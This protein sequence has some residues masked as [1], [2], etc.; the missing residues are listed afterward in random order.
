MLN[1]VKT[2]SLCLALC[3]PL[4]AFGQFMAPPPTQEIRDSIV[5]DLKEMRLPLSPEWRFYSYFTADALELNVSTA[6]A[7]QESAQS[8]MHLAMD[9]FWNPQI[10]TNSYEAAGRGIY[11]G[12]DPLISQKYGDTLLVLSIKDDGE[13]YFYLPYELQWSEKTIRLFEEMSQDL[14]CLILDNQYSTAFGKGLQSRSCREFKKF[15][16]ETFTELKIIGMEYRFG[17][18]LREVCP[19]NLSASAFVF[20]G[21]PKFHSLSG[22]AETSI[23]DV[24][25]LKEGL[26]NYSQSELAKNK[27]LESLKALMA[28]GAKKSPLSAAQIQSIQRKIYSCE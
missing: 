10:G 15:I 20:F 28:T 14:G 27:E 5:I 23:F 18:F 3:M 25:I 9:Y 16:L 12:I 7:R 8:R 21:Q 13:R 19:V 26:K 17:T 22:V 24:Q 2:I 6:D 4:T 11:A 1:S